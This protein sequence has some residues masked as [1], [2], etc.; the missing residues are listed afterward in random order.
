MLKVWFDK[1][2]KDPKLNKFQVQ[3]VFNKY[4]GSPKKLEITI[5]VGE[6]WRMNLCPRID[7][8]YLLAQF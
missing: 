6:G 3:I 2:I 1:K 8:N 7:I 5:L 4:V